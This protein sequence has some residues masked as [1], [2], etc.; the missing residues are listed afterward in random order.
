MSRRRHRLKVQKMKIDLV[1]RTYT[2][3]AF[4]VC[5]WWLCRLDCRVRTRIY[6]ILLRCTAGW[7]LIK[8]ISKSYTE[9]R[10]SQSMPDAPRCIRAEV[11][12]EEFPFTG[13][14]WK[15]NTK[16]YGL[17]RLR[18]VRRT[19]IEILELSCSFPKRILAPK[20]ERKYFLLANIE[21]IN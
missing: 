14:D 15:E 13:G 11:S 21:L 3:H 18:T 6:N 4:C 10:V 8:T 17:N 9:K 7:R 2:V 19:L 1:P 16:K 12:K 20:G 5:S